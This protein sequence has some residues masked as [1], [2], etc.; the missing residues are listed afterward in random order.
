VDTA[1]EVLEAARLRAAALAT[2]D[3]QGL[4]QLLHP[5]YRWFTHTGERFDRESFVRSN[6]EGSTRWDRQELTEVKVVAHERTAVLHCQVVDAV[7]HGAGVEELRMPMTQVWVRDGGRWV[8]LAG[9]AGPSL[10]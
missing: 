8:C 6:T 7:D 10:S 2:G 4:R 1:E 3:P 5:Q 9:H